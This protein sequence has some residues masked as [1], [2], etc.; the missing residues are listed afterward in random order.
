MINK[1]ETSN[2]NKEG[3]E[4]RMPNL[5]HLT[6]SLP[7]N[8]PYNPSKPVTQIVYHVHSVLKEGEV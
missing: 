5:P 1:G 7:Q 4:T 8:S 6:G 2:H 3:N